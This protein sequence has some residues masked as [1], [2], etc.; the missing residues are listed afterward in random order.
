ML[1]VPSS[2]TASFL[3]E[4]VV[5]KYDR[6]ST[7]QNRVFDTLI[8]RT[9]VDSDITRIYDLGC[10][11]GLNTVRWAEKYQLAHVRGIDF[12]APVIDFARRKHRHDRVRYYCQNLQDWK[13]S[14]GPVSD[15]IV[16][17][18]CLHWI[19]PLE[20]FLQRLLPSL[21]E[22][23]HF[24]FSTFGPETY[25]EIT[26]TLSVTLDNHREISARLFPKAPNILSVLKTYF[27]NVS[28]QETRITTLYPN[29]LTLFKVIKNTGTGGS[30]VDKQGLW[31]PRLL[32][33]LEHNY[34]QLY[35]QIQATHQIFY[36]QAS[37]KK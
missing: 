13:A 3:R 12:S 32:K 15:L 14:S 20:P 31:T 24:S 30:G 17:N 25:S 6:Y 28:F 10:G 4:D 36:F 18:A 23:G 9:K 8:D 35:A 27:S 22:N 11:T 7:V 37:V 33:K 2:K 21:S 5:S 1:F 26:H 16:S 19:D 34:R 29:L